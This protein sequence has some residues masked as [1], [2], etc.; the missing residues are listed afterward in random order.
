MTD[1]DARAKLTEIAQDIK[2]GGDF[3]QM[4]KEHSDDKGSGSKGGEL[5]WANPG[6]FVP[7]FEAT[8]DEMEPGD[9]SDPVRSS[10]GWHLIE[11]METR[12][13]DNSEEASL[14]E[15]YGQVRSR[16]LEQETERWLLQLRDEAFV[17]YR[18]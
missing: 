16:K 15:A 14:N 3:A 8:L 13:K 6:N 10:F 9:T 2:E 1:A 12:E 7:E 4:A 11:L 18:T 17:D 5:G